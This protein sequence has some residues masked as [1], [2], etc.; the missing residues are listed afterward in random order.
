MNHIWFASHNTHKIQELESL[1]NP[2]GWN[3][4]GIGEAGLQDEIDETG[5]DLKENARIKAE[6][7]FAR[8]NETC[9]SDDSGLEVDAL[10]GRPGVHSARFAGQPPDSTKNINLLLS[11]MQGQVNR[12][13]QLRTIICLMWANTA[14][15]FEGSVAGQ[16]TL[17]PRGAGGFGYDPIFMPNGYHETFAEMPSELKNCISH[18]ARAVRQLIDFLKA[19]KSKIILNSLK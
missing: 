7:A 1:L 4:R 2:M 10:N 5:L 18:R 9:I 15:F 19:N 13:A 8:L 16:I 3:I 6:F 11:N 12:K 17:E 14:Y